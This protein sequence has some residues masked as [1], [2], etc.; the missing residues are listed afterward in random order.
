MYNPA[1]F[2]IKTSIL[3]LYRRIFVVD[4]LNRSFNISLW[5]TGVFVLLYCLVQA[6]IT[7]FYCTP[8]KM[9]WNPTVRGKCINYDDV[10]TT[11]AALNIGTDV[12]ILC[13]PLPQLWKL[14][15][16]KRIKRQLAG[17]FL[18]GGL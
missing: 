3:L 1:I 8:M 10:L 17:I 9:L 4:G 2:A 7:V 12:L 16:P 14:Q 13:L 6:V 18:L 5:C 15:L 11:M